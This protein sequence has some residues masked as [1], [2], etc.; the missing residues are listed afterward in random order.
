M[1][2][3]MWAFGLVAALG[4]CGANGEAPPPAAPQ[5]GDLALEAAE[6]LQAQLLT[7][8]TP[9]AT[10]VLATAGVPRRDLVLPAKALSPRQFRLEGSEAGVNRVA[11]VEYVPS[12]PSPRYAIYVADA[13]APDAD[14]V[15]VYAGAK[16]VQSVALGQQGALL[17][18]A[19]EGIDGSYDIFLA[20]LGGVFGSEGV[21]YLLDDRP[22]DQLDVSMSLD[23][24]H[25]AWSH[26]GGPVNQQLVVLDRDVTSGRYTAQ[27]VSM[28]LGERRI[29]V[30]TPRLSGDGNYVWM[31]ADN[32]IVDQFYGAPVIV[33][34]VRDT[35]EAFVE[36]A[37][38][39]SVT[40]RLA[41]PSGSAGGD[42][43]AFIEDH[44]GQTYLS[45]LHYDSPTAGAARLDITIDPTVQDAQVTA[46]GLGVA[47]TQGG[48]VVLSTVDRY[49]LEQTTTVLAGPSQASTAA[50]WPQPLPAPPTGS[51][52]Y[53]NSLT[54]ESPTFVRPGWNAVRDAVAEMYDDP[55]LAEPP[56]FHYHA[57]PF[58]VESGGRY[59]VDPV[60]ADFETWVLLYEDDFDPEDPDENLLLSAGLTE[61]RTLL[62]EE[63]VFYVLVT[64]SFYPVGCAL[65]DPDGPGIGEFTNAVVA[66]TPLGPGGLRFE[67][68]EAT[69]DIAEAGVDEV[70]VTYFVSS[71]TD[72]TCQVDWGDG[73]TETVDC[74]RNQAQNA[75]H[76]YEEPGY[77]DVTITA[78]NGG[79][80]VAT[81]VQSV[82]EDAPGFQITVV[83]REQ[84]FINPALRDQVFEAA[85]RWQR[86]INTDYPAVREE[87][88]R[89]NSNTCRFS[90]FVDDHA[91]LVGTGFRATSALAW[92]S[93]CGRRSAP[94]PDIPYIGYTQLNVRYPLRFEALGIVD[95]VTHEM[96][97]ALGFIDSFFNRAGYLDA[98]NPDDPRFTGPES[99]LVYESL[100]GEPADSVPLEDVGSRSHWRESEFDIE[101]MTSVNDGD[102]PNPLSRLSGALMADLGWSVTD[103]AS[104]Y[105]AFELPSADVNARPA[106]HF[107]PPRDLVLPEGLSLAEAQP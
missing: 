98:T 68:L 64:T 103:D 79:E 94:D 40:T 69:P 29:P 31:V 44:A 52:A 18:F 82:A 21:L 15:L 9:Q 81:Y 19:A 91:L 5:F 4:A 71:D 43:V 13:D 67:S 88:F 80:E 83:F 93:S 92:A 90:G 63:G 100:T 48:R 104:A 12:W 11:F 57:L 27:T 7:D 56:L 39:P 54:D 59:T 89:P 2:P 36:Y 3:R 75:S 107:H 55:C 61:P 53:T 105:D 76:L 78:N 24:G 97:H 1:K 26:R 6:P 47:Y 37:G 16:E 58:A 10:E 33:A 70:T 25:L 85:L 49:S 66:P 45:M 73:T 35:Q 106:V 17:G 86:I 32:D 87:S 51:L 102:V 84:E 46:S 65:G 96:G 42:V 99:L 34:W 60:E 23:G 50:T 38:T 77:F 41:K 8:Q 72:V 62:L 74:V 95:I 30:G 14:P 22:G 101:L 20:D 28:T